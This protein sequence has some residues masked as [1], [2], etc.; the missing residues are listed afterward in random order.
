MTIISWL[1]D[2]EYLNATFQ[3]PAP[4][5]ITWDQQYL[6]YVVKFLRSNL[7]DRFERWVQRVP[8]APFVFQNFVNYQGDDPLGF[9]RDVL[10]AYL[11]PVIF[12]F[13]VLPLIWKSIKLIFRVT[14]EMCWKEVEIEVEADDPRL[15]AQNEADELL[16]KA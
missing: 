1:E 4:V 3:F 5:I 15:I 2:R 16:K 12:I 6:L 8:G 11:S 7:G 10:T 9:K 14:L 13:V